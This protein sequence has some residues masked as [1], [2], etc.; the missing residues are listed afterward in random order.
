MLICP[1][2]VIETTCVI[3][4]NTT[5]LHYFCQVT[6]LLLLW[7]IILDAWRS[8]CHAESMQPSFF[9]RNMSI[10]QWLFFLLLI[11]PAA[12]SFLGS[13]S[14]GIPAAGCPSNGDG[15][16]CTDSVSPMPPD[17]PPQDGGIA[18]TMDAK[19]CPD[20]SYV[21]RQP[22]TCEFAPCP[23]E[24]TGGS[25]ERTGQFCGGIAAIK[26]PKGQQCVLD[27]TYPDAGGTC[28]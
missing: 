5:E 25:G 26:C 15:V 16:Y 1:C 20:G 8:I 9:S 12:G 6:L 10:P 4:I 14:A 24:T 11:L 2:E 27:G 18:C 22:P 28:Q 23:G 7:N 17:V 19:G 13:R 3:Y 21:S